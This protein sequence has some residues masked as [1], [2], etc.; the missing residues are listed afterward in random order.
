MFP[1][2]QEARIYSLKKSLNVKGIQ[3]KK[4]MHLKMLT[5][6]KIQVNGKKIQ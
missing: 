5:R 4:C 3:E 2:T 1:S 6:N